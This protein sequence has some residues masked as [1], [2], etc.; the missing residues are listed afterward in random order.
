M[1][2]M[3][4]LK[5]MLVGLFALLGTNGVFAQAPAVA[6]EFNDDD[7]FYY[8][9]K[10][11]PATKTA[12]LRITALNGN[13]T[14]EITI[15][16][17]FPKKYGDDTWT[18]NVVRINDQVFLDQTGLTKVTF[19]KELK[20]IGAK[21]FKGCTLLSAIKFETGSELELLGNQAFATTQIVAP[22]FSP[23]TKLTYLPNLLFVEST[24]KMNSYVTSI[25]LPTSAQFTN[26]NTALAN[27]PKLATTNIKDTKIQTVVA[28]AF[29]NDAMLTALELP[30]T[31]K[32]IEASAFEKSAVATLTIDLTS[33]ESIGDGTTPLYSGTE[34]NGKVLTTLTMK[35]PLKG[36]IKGKAFAETGTNHKLAGVLD[37][38]AVKLGTTGT[39][40]SEAFGGNDLLTAVK[41]GIIENNTGSKYTIQKNAF[42]GAKLASVTISNITTAKAIEGEAFNK[43]AADGT[44]ENVTI[45][46]IYTAG[47]A[48]AE[49]AF[50]FAKAKDAT[51]TIGNV[52][53][54]DATTP[55]MASGAFDF[56]L[57]NGKSIKVQIGDV[58]A[59]HANFNTG[60]F[61]GQ[62]TEISFGAIEQTALDVKLISDNSKLTKITFN[63]TIG[64]GGIQPLVFDGIEGNT[65]TPLAITFVG[66]M[67]TGAVLDDAFRVGVAPG[68]EGKARII[69]DYQSATH[70][71]PLGMPFTQ[72]A[73]YDSYCTGNYRD[74]L[75]KPMGNTDLDNYFR[76]HQTDASST[77]D[78]VWRIMLA[79][80]VPTNFFEV[81]ADDTKAGTSYA[82]ILLPAG[83]KYKIDRRP[84]GEDA[85]G[86]DQTGIT[87]HLYVTYKEEDAPSKVTNLNMLPMV[88]TDGFYYVDCS[89]MTDDLV[90]IVKATGVKAAQQSGEKKVT[91]MWYDEVTTITTPSNV[92]DGDETVKVASAVATN[93]QL[94]DGNGNPKPIVTASPL[95]TTDDYLTKAVLEANDLYLL[96]NPANNKGISAI[97]INYWDYSDP[98]I[99]KGYYYALGT[100]YGSAGRMIINWI[101]DDEATGIIE[102]KTAAKAVNND[103]IYNL[104]GVRV[105]AT[106]KGVYIQNGKK[107]IV[108]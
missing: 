80:P 27:L 98:F 77:S 65:T 16:G 73:F 34:T 11:T 31:V 54:T 57:A 26:F 17:H 50:Y 95:T 92:W 93:Q 96:T 33:I 4:S 94:R 84:V 69:V 62:V 100:K 12:E 86:V 71:N 88:S 24:T 5:L 66:K 21:V 1:K 89:S 40:A 13:K 18:M 47:A 51:L 2:K 67:A 20:N 10:V 44:L 82:R 53:S 99:D 76:A 41:L 37:M 97:K 61:K 103:V 15:K 105:N 68:S 108:K 90:V 3:K 58:E 25:T 83:G 63:S 14:G 72:K 43:N 32:T 29:A 59:K 22:D 49:K 45:G 8:V 35:N 46:N 48:I 81:Y 107:F 19:P 78:I 7:Y 30:G 91:K 23:C 39:I 38:E 79:P 60:S 101:G 102:T 36:E 64:E 74:I 85:D 6:D 42:Y 56:T 70:D 106:Q 52:R 75:L 87:Y 28:G 104:Q 55:V 9:S